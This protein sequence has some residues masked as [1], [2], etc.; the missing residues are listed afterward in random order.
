MSVININL[1]SMMLRR[2]IDVTVVL[3]D[4]INDDEK[5]PCVWLYHGGSGDHT[6]WLF[7]TLLWW[8]LLTNA[9]LRLFCQKYLNPAL[10]I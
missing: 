9:I 6:E 8:I 1:F 2:T 10:S 4:K 7:I 5:L 3:P